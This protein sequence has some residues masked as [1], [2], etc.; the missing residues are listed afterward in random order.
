[1]IE[2]YPLPSTD[3]PTDAPFWEW[4]LRDELRVQ[5]CADCD[6]LRFPPRPVCP[7]C[8]SFAHE[9]APLSG[10]GRIWSLTVPRPPL[11][12]H[13]RSLSPYAVAVVELDEDPCVR[14]VGNLVPSAATPD[15]EINAVDPE[16]VEIGA[17]VEAVFH[18]AAR[19][20][21]IPRWALL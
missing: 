10:R 19:D 11:L 21:A 3:D 5:R 12:P 20:V 8:R 6:R 15:A 16:S 1:M 7:H 14:M 18:R 17:R 9:W 4:A 13:F 2:G